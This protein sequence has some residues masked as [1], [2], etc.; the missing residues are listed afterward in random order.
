[1][2][3]V[4][5]FNKKDEETSKKVTISMPTEDEIAILKALTAQ[6]DSETPV[7][8]AHWDGGC[9]KAFFDQVQS[10]ADENEFDVWDCFAVFLTKVLGT[11]FVF[12]DD[13][14]ISVITRGNDE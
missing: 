12:N 4:V 7:D 2:S 1:M 5:P 8:I 3:N 10:Y 6:Y 13:G 9:W 14:S 11:E